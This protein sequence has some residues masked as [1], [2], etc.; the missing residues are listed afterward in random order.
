M[1]VFSAGCSLDAIEAVCSE[2]SESVLDDLESL[3]DKALI[4]TAGPADRFQ[5]LQ[6]I[7]DFAREELL[8]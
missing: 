4:Q 7:K 3:V 8:A 6:T 2:N 5:M 1:S